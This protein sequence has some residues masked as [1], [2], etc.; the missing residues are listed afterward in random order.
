MKR[1]FLI[2]GLIISCFIFGKVDARCNDDNINAMANDI[3][4]GFNI[5]GIDKDGEIFKTAQ[6]LVDRV[7]EDMFLIIINNDTNEKTTIKD[8]KDGYATVNA[9]D[10]HNVYDYTVKIY[11][12]NPACENELLRTVGS[13]SLIFNYQFLRDECAALRNDENYKQDFK[14]CDEYTSETYSDETFL[15]EYDLYINKQPE[16]IK[17][18]IKDLFYKYYYFALI[19]MVLLGVYYVIR[20]NIIK[21]RKKKDEEE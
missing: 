2:L 20:V 6:L 12:S 13:S 8:I 11:S 7:P 15:K 5:V 21:R 17:N 9:P 14:Y 10:I 1:K 3:E 18:T 19:P 4:V 16:Q